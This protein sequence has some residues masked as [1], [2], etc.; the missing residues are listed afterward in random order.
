MD[1]RPDDNLDAESL[2]V[3][4][5]R[6]DCDA[7]DLPAPTG[8]VTRVRQRGER[9][10]RRRQRVRAVATMVVVGGVAAAG[11]VLNRPQ[12]ER[13]AVIRPLPPTRPSAATPSID[14]DALRAEYER[15]KQECEAREA[16]VA[17]ALDAERRRQF[18]RSDP[19]L[20]IEWQRELAA[21][22]LVRQGDRLSEDL[23]LPE[24]AALAYL[25]ARDTFPGTQWAAVAEAR[26]A[27]AGYRLE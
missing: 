20:E 12:P 22:A 21:L 6:A 16:A 3:L 2:D 18:A 13:I 25:E 5:R 11:V 7:G 27:A 26:L 23:S 8:V 1:P 9:L 17:R 4:L 19:L 15:L 14:V 24:P 10:R